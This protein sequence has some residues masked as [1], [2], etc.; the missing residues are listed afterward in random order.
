MKQMGFDKEVQKVEEGICP[1]CNKVVNINNFK[2][3]LSKT[4]FLISGLCQTC[5]DGFFNEDNEDEK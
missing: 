4:E 1:F 2:N 5:Q 3:E